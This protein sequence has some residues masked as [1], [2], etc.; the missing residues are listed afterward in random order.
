MSNKSSFKL[1][2]WLMIGLLAGVLAL[3]ILSSGCAGFY[4]RM[5][6][7]DYHNNTGEKAK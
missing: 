5:W 4:E 6:M 2:D 3:L 7:H 1:A